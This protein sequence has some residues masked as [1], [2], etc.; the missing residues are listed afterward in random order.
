MGLLGIQPYAHCLVKNLLGIPN[1][2]EVYDMMALG[3]PAEKARP[4]LVRNREEMVHFDYRG[5]GTFRDDQAVKDF[6]I[7]M[8]GILRL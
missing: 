1:E 5:E 4:R 3:Y 8:K 6:I 2:L 7:K